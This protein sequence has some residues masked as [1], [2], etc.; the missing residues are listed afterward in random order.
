MEEVIAY[1]MAFHGPILDN[2]DIACVP[3]QKKYWN[4]YM[5]IYNECFF[6]MRKALEIEPYNFYSAYSQIEDKIDNVFLYLDH[7]QIVGAVSC[8][9]NEVDDLIVNK[10]F[11][12]NG[13]GKKILLW[14]MKHIQ[15]KGIEDVILH[16]AEWNKGAIELYINAGY[17]IK[18]KERVR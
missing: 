10:Q 6:E 12:R 15:E 18:R 2:V 13:Y 1:E 5:K 11:Q 8:Y 9:G 3:F 14:G 7:E 16:V 4:E 17:V